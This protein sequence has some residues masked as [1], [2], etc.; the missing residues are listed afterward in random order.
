MK[1]MKSKD[2]PAGIQVIALA[3]IAIALAGAPILA[4]IRWFM[5]W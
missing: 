3:F 1:M 5:G 2:E 4:L